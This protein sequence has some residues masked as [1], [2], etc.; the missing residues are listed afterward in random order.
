[1]L[2]N[3]RRAITYLFAGLCKHRDL[4]PKEL[5]RQRSLLWWEMAQLGVSREEVNL[6]CPEE[7]LGPVGEGRVA[8]FAFEE[9][10][11][12]TVHDCD[13]RNSVFGYSWE[14]DS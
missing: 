6:V 12:A 8:S 5:L 9:R 11:S 10:A 13:A 1:M 7:P 2:A 14:S 4:K 3:R